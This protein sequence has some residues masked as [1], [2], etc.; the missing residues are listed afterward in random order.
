M[1]LALLVG[2]G[3]LFLELV[4]ADTKL[5]KGLQKT[6]FDDAP[7]ECLATFDKQLACDDRVQLVAYDI[8]SLEL[9]TSDLT[10]LCT[11]SCENS[12]QALDSAVSSACGDYDISFNGAYISAAGVVDSSV[13]KYQMICLVDSSGD[14]CLDVEST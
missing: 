13:Y 10:D 5:F 6:L 12:L 8:D 7:S 14:F 4:T 3:A 11:P 2:A 9:E 1:A